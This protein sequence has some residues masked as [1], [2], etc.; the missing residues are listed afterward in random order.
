MSLKYRQLNQMKD[1]RLEVE[2]K[3]TDGSIIKGIIID[4]DENDVCIDDGSSEKVIRLLSISE[5]N[6]RKNLE[7]SITPQKITLGLYRI[8]VNQKEIIFNTSYSLKQIDWGKI[9]KYDFVSGS[10]ISARDL[11]WSANETAQERT[12]RLKTMRIFPKEFITAIEPYLLRNLDT[13]EISEVQRAINFIREQL[14]LPLIQLTSM[15]QVLLQHITINQIRSDINQH[16][17][18]DKIYRKSFIEQ[19]EDKDSR[20]VVSRY[21]NP[22][23]RINIVIENEEIGIYGSLDAIYKNMVLIFKI[24]HVVNTNI[25]QYMNQLSAYH[26]MTVEGGGEVNGEKV[27]RTGIV[28]L[29]QDEGLSAKDRLLQSAITVKNLVAQ[30]RELGKTGDMAS[31]VMLLDNIYGRDFGRGANV[32]FNRLADYIE[33]VNTELNEGD[34]WSMG[35]IPVLGKEAMDAGV[36]DINLAERKYKEDINLLSQVKRHEWNETEIHENLVNF[37]Y[38]ILNYQNEIA[39]QIQSIHQ[40]GYIIIPQGTTFK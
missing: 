11:N 30:M 8:Q 9:A 31:K 12:I 38:R 20:V 27:G 17:F 35:V 19:L 7:T 6:R 37:A 5:I 24:E 40:N 3:L 21:K 16:L 14:K 26:M 18:E 29:P 2:L 22:N 33:R 10:R 25:S 23:L 36:V 15:E 13:Y 34:D 4:L 28:P 32:K 1:E 39:K